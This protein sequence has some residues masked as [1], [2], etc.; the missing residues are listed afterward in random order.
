[1]WPVIR[2]RCNVLRQLHTA[3]IWHALR[4][5]TFAKK[6]FFQLYAI[7]Y[8]C[9]FRTI[10]IHPFVVWTLDIPDSIPG[11]NNLID[12]ALLN[13]FRPGCSRLCLGL[14][15]VALEYSESTG[16]TLKWDQVIG[17]VVWHIKKCGECGGQWCVQWT[18]VKESSVWFPESITV[19]N[20]FGSGYL[21]T[22][23]EWIPLHWYS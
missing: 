19:L 12:F 1:M 10:T 5:L 3:V 16:T 8:N 2:G 22:A 23:P 6:G 17:V 9:I 21:G 13:W 14:N 15:S 11:G 20:S 4:L 18:Q 7:N